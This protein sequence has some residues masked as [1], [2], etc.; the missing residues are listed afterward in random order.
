[1]KKRLFQYLLGYGVSIAVAVFVI[2]FY[3]TEHGYNFQNHYAK[4]FSDSALINVVMFVGMWL[5]TL[6]SQQG[7]F[8]I[9][10]YSFKKL[11]ASMFK[12]TERY[13]DVPKTF[14]DYRVLKQEEERHYVHYLG[15]I[16]GTWAI[17][18]IIFTIIY[19][20]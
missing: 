14:Y 11:R 17:I 7:T 2:V 1:M 12:K 15:V 8:D 20:N 13:Q 9:F 6:I 4:I 19:L 10:A 18:A 3:L 16:G 5:L